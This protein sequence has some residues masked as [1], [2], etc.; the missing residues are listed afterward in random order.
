[1]HNPAVQILRSP[2]LRGLIVIAGVVVGLGGWSGALLADELV[3]TM[4]RDLTTLGYYSDPIDGE[5]DLPTQ[6]AIGKF[7]EA[8]AMPVTGEATL[9]LASKISLAADQGAATG[10]AAA[11]TA[12]AQADAA[13]VAAR[14]QCLDEKKAQAEASKQKRKLFGSLGKAGGNLLGRFGGAGAAADVYKASAT[15]DDVAAISDAMGLDEAD[16]SECMAIGTEASATQ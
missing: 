8:N 3:E 4:Q 13:T 2:K 16:V 10:G 5:L 12:A 6:L 1:M 15:V 11:E 14:E 7:E 9:A